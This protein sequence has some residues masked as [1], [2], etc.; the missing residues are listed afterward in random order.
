[1]HDALVVCGGQAGRDLH[2]VIDR[3]ARCEPRAQDVAQRR[4]VE[5]LGHDVE[6]VALGADVVDGQD[7]RMVDGRG[8]ARLALEPPSAVRILRPIRG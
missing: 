5:Q 2:R 4:A 3:P 8:G 6:D 7:V 1:V